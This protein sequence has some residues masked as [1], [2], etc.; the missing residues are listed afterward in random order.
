M[1]YS[2]LDA[3]IIQF[4]NLKVRIV[5]VVLQPMKFKTLD[6]SVKEKFQALKINKNKLKSIICKLLIK[7]TNK[8]RNKFKSLMSNYRE[9]VL[10]TLIKELKI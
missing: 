4:P 2:T 8:F 3:K 6:Y 1:K 7:K 10:N 5:L 9:K